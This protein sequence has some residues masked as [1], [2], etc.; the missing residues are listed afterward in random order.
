MSVFFV[1]DKFKTNRFL[2]VHEIFVND[3]LLRHG[4]AVPI[5][6]ITLTLDGF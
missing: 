4:R 2:L 6:F 5:Y 3:G 1:K